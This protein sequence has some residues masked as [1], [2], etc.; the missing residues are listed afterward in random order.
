MSGTR[1][2]EP[3]TFQKAS[4]YYISDAACINDYHPILAQLWQVR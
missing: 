4:V 2:T 3:D 1:Y